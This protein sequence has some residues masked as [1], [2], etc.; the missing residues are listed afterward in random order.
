MELVKFLKPN[1]TKVVI[2]LIFIIISILGRIQTYA[3]S[4]KTEPPPIL[5]NEINGLPFWELWIFI[6]FPIHL[7]V[8]I[9]YFI[10]GEGPLSVFNNEYIFWI[11]SMIYLYALSCFISSFIQQ[12]KQG[13]KTK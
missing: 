4:E 10:F 6:N 5:Y 1:K 3:F 11:I 8:M 9:V 2:F 12:E 13:K 7:V